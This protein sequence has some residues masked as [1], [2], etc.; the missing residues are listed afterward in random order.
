MNLSHDDVVCDL[1]QYYNIYDFRRLPPCKV[2]VFVYGL[3]YNSRIKKRLRGQEYDL[4]TL[5]IARAVDNLSFLCWA[6]TKDG[7]KNRNRPASLLE[8]LLNPKETNNKDDIETFESGE[9]FRNA[10]EKITKKGD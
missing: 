3:H 2:A 4:E 8:S 9:D 6:K 10:F 5:M 7:E 1:A